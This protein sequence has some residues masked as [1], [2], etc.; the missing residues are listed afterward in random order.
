VT[1]HES[2]ILDILHRVLWSQDGK[3]YCRAKAILNT[4]FPLS[5]TAQRVVKEHPAM[6]AALHASLYDQ[7]GR[8]RVDGEGK[9]L[10]RSF[11]QSKILNL[12]ANPYRGPDALLLRGLFMDLR[13]E[14]GNDYQK[15][16]REIFANLRL[17]GLAETELA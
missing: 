14:M 9:P 3:E 17:P 8:L 11:I 7:R 2:I 10:D 15:C 13:K 1:D 4:G 5:E 12:K 16:W 6:V